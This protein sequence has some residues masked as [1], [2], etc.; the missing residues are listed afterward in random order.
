MLFAF[1]LALRVP[2]LD[3]D[4]GLHAAIAQE[5][6]ERRAYLTPTF[7]SR[8]FLDKPVLFFWAQ[9]ASLRALGM[10]E[11]AVRFPGLLFALLGCVTTAILGWRL[12]G[13][14]VG[15]LAGCFH[16]TLLL[17]LAVSQA[18][19]H[20]V[21]LVPWTNL[22]LLALWE[23]HRAAAP[24]AARRWTGAAGLAFGLAVLT[25][26][27]IGSACVLQRPTCSWPSPRTN[28]RGSIAMG[29]SPMFRSSRRARSGC[30][31]RASCGWR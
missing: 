16:A 20:D 28:W 15:A 6:V 14:A 23:A 2:L 9:A 4:E 10:T 11:A 18:A 3:P 19:V 22:G 29:G 1:P 21:A 17:P 26:G 24:A 25:K 5:M 27:L 31:R 12:L 7:L 30:I 8:P 13:P